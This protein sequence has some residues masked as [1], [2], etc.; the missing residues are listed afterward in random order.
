[1]LPEGKGKGGCP[2]ERSYIFHSSFRLESSKGSISNVTFSETLL[3]L[4]RSLS[5]YQFASP[6][7]VRQILVTPGLVFSADNEPFRRFAPIGSY[8]E[9][10]RGYVTTGGILFAARCKSA[11]DRT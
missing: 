1:M 9:S 10:D 6:L 2:E 5:T 3:R 4:I 7:D 8:V 11:K